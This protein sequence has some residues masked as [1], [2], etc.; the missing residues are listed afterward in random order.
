M[1]RML[2]FSLLLAV[3]LCGCGPAP[4]VL[5][6]PQAEKLVNSVDGLL[7]ALVPGAVI[8][9]APGTYDLRQASD[10]GRDLDQEYYAWEDSGDGYALVLRGLTDVTIRGAGREATQIVIQPRYA[11]VLKLQNCVNVTLEGFTA[12]HVYGE[13][14]CTGGVLTLRGCLDV[15]LKDL[16]LYGCG[17]T[18]VW[19]DLCTN[20]HISGSHIYDCTSSGVQANETDG[21]VVENCSFYDLGDKNW[22]IGAVFSLSF[23]GDVRISDSYI[24]DNHCAFLVSAVPAESLTVE[25]CT[26]ARNRVAD[27]AFDCATLVLE[28]NT[29]EENT[30]RCWFPYT[31]LTAR[32]G[33]G[34]TLTEEMLE[35]RYGGMAA[36]AP[37]E[38]AL[39]QVFTV[40]ELLAAI[41][42][43]TEILLA[44]GF[45]DLSTAQGYGVENTQYYYWLEEFDGPSLVIYG[46]DNLTIRGESGDV[47]LCT[48][49][50]VPRYA[51]VLTF[52]N[53]GNIT[54]SG[55]TA[56]HT[57]EPGECAGGVILAEYTDGFLVENC[58]LYG[59]GILGLE[60][61][62]C[63]D[64]SVRGCEIYECSYGGIRMYGVNGAEV[65]SC[66]FRDLGGESLGF[67]DCMYVIIDGEPVNGD[68]Y[69]VN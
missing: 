1:K 55:F 16:G 61:N 32:D 5:D 25:N 40:D 6:A 2:V 65:E 44:D 52:N 23:C 26:F 47:N 27:A 20:V 39:V 34:V 53:C 30:L 37:V 8:E 62:G 9:L 58:S 50:A 24:T 3:L 14:A 64:V 57:V 68:Y 13:N 21:L 56:G 67:N 17:S 33:Q 28:G 31:G 4:E 41:G 66:S 45:Y 18:G 11:D 7:D 19:A 69:Y 51:D 12:G 48:I 29:F 54:L 59:C 63:T 60:A 36:A 15:E 10:Y 43:N 35:E 49:S 42:P 38:Q 46:V 22:Y